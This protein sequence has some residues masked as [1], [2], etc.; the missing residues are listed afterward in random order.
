MEDLQSRRLVIFIVSLKEKKNTSA[1][2]IKANVWELFFS[3]VIMSVNFSF[4]SL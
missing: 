1:K 3:D 4:G 2:K